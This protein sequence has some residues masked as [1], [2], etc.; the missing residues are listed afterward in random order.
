MIIIYLTFLVFYIYKLRILKIT[1]FENY[2]F[3][4]INVHVKFRKN[5]VRMRWLRTC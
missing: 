2:V 3:L 1:Y 5:I 4:S